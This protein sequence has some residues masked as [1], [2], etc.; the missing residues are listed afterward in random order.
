[1]NPGPGRKGGT[2]II[3][4][5]PPGSVRGSV[6]ERSDWGN[7]GRI[8]KK[9]KKTPGLTYRSDYDRTLLPGG[10]KKRDEIDGKTPYPRARIA[11]GGGGGVLEVKIGVQGRVKPSGAVGLTQRVAIA[12]HG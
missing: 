3:P 10:P 4:L 5:R 8:R 7:D 6:E 9:V 11:D 12:S 1:V 2:N